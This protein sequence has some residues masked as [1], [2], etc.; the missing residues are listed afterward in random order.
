[1]CM[2]QGALNIVLRLYLP[3]LVD[4]ELSVTS[5]DNHTLSVVIEKLQNRS[6]DLIK[7]KAELNNNYIN[8]GKA[9]DQLQK[10]KDEIERRF[11]NLTGD[12]RK[13]GWI[14]FQSSLYYMSTEQRSWDESR[15]D[16]RQ[17]E[18]DLVIINSREEQDF[19]ELLRRGNSAWIGLTDREKESEWKWVDGTPLTSAYWWTKEPSNSNGDEDCA[20]TGYKPVDGRPVNDLI[21]T[22]NDNS[23]SGRNSWICEKIIAL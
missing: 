15:Q 14:I 2:V 18:A 10:E 9:R 20:E 21:S 8:L 12:I 19:I 1:M 22:W 3:P 7:E 13:P 11:S 5:C 4:T 6:R 23:C 16:C 17:R